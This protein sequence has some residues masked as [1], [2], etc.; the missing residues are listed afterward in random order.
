[1]NVCTLF[2]PVRSTRLKLLPGLGL[3]LVLCACGAAVDKGAPDVNPQSSGPAFVWPLSGWITAT[4]SYWTGKIHTLGSADISAAYAQPVVAARGG[5]VSE[6]GF[7]LS[8]RF[9]FYVRLRHASGYETLYAH[10]LA[11]PWVRA[12]E[13]VKVRQTLG[14]SGRTGNAGL[15]HL[16][17]AVLKNGAEVR[18]PEIDF[19][20]WV[21]RGAP[22]PG[23]Y[24]GLT[25]L[26]V[27]PAPLTVRVD[28]ATLP[29]KKL[30]S[31]GSSVVRWLERGT[32]LEVVGGSGGFYRVRYG[33]LGGY[34]VSSGVVPVGSPVYGI[35]THTTADA[36]LTPDPAAKVVTTFAPNTVLSAFGSE[37]GFYKTQWRDPNSFVQYVYLPKTAATTTSRFWVRGVLAPTM[38]VRRGPGTS[39]DVV[40]TLK[41]SPYTPE[42]LVTE[43]VRGWYKV[44]SERWLPGWQ[45]LRR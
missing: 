32:R 1:M 27:A 2:S 22:L 44:G 24:A 5:T 12:G 36:R 23:S 35:R 43:N 25:P 26:T 42:Y 20:N 29:L 14:R 28:V 4:D 39:Y 3:L 34:V 41:F 33:D 15:P 17:F 38:Q 10:L 21:D 30:A 37:N 31:T 7:S 13:V 11:A 9:G 16:H 40:Q 8:P 45:T 6:A 19:G 18:V